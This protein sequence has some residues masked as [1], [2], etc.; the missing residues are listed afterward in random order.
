[1]TK[2]GNS[3]GLT[4]SD[5]T[6]LGGT[7]TISGTTPAFSS[8]AELPVNG[9]YLFVSTAGWTGNGA[10]IACSGTTN[11]SPASGVSLNY[12]SNAPKEPLA[13]ASSASVYRI[14]ALFDGGMSV[15][16]VRQE[17]PS[18]SSVQ[19]EYIRGYANSVSPELKS[20]YPK[21]SFK[22]FLLGELRGK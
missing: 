7:I 11:S 5:Q 13:G 3:I 21:G 1:M 18:L 10:A 22:Q 2:S 19:L 14:G 17:F 6:M 8:G 9:G 20:R 15:A 16:Q 4:S 12:L